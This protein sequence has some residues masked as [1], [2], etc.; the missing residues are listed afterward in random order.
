MGKAAREAEQERIRI[1]NM[2]AIA[3]DLAVNA[4]RKIM[5]I[6][7]EVTPVEVGTQYGPTNG[8]AL[9]IVTGDNEKH[10]PYIMETVGGLNMIAAITMTLTGRGVPPPPPP[11]ENTP[12]ENMSADNTTSADVG[13]ASTITPSGLIV[14]TVTEVT[15]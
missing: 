12:V 14:P 4:S 11:V 9:H 1:Q 10:G 2:A 6:G 13:G 3:T 7:V 8:V 15:S 5:V